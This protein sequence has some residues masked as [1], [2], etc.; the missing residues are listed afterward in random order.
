MNLRLIGG[1]CRGAEQV[2]PEA[3]P[4]AAGVPQGPVAPP[5]RSP[6]RVHHVVGKAPLGTCV[7]DLAVAIADPK[8]APFREALQALWRVMY[9]GSPEPSPAAAALHFWTGAAGAG[10]AGEQPGPA[11]V[12]DPAAS[13]RLGTVHAAGSSGSSAG[14]CLR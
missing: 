14:T 7:E 9:P 1:A 10:A 3:A 13:A 11:A 5:Q 12:Q 8:M 6:N 2:G 4:P